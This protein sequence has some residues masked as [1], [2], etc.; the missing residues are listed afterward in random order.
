MVTHANQGRDTYLI[1]NSLSENS[2]SAIGKWSDA[3]FEFQERYDKW[4][5]PKPGPTPL[6]RRHRGL[7]LPE[8]GTVPG[9]KPVSEARQAGF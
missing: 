5:R 6:H 9:G 3:N 7:K 8:R 4:R 1:R 2:R